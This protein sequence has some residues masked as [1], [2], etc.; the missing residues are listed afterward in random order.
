MRSRWRPLRNDPDPSY[1]YERRA[2]AESAEARARAA[3]LDASIMALHDFIEQH[4]SPEDWH[5]AGRAEYRVRFEDAELE[6][7]RR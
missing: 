1:T 4:G 6:C 5:A 2:A 3:S 7:L